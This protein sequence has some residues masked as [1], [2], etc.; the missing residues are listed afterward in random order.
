[1]VNL[2]Q[3]QRQI[4]SLNNGDVNSRREAIR[5][6]TQYERE[7]WAEVPAQTVRPLI[8]SL[9]RQLSQGKQ[10]VD[11]IALPTFRQEVATILGKIGPGSEVAVP[12]LVTLLEA[13]VADGVRE[14]AATALGRIG[15]EARRAVGDL[16]G[17]LTPECRVS[18]AACVAGALGEI[19]CA[20]QRVRSALMNLWMLPIRCDNSRSQ[21]AIALCKLRLEAPGLIDTLAGTLAG[22]AKVGARQTAAE[23]LSWCGKDT[24]G[25]VP[26][27]LAALYD[28]DEQV[29][30]TAEAGL[31]RLRLSQ[32]KAIQICC[33]QLGDCPLAQ[34][35][36]K[37]SGALAVEPLIEVLKSKKAPLREKAAQTLGSLKEIAAPAAAALTAALNDKDWSVRL[38][39]AKALW[40]V[41][42]QAEVVVPTLV[43]LLKRNGLPSA[44]DTADTAELRRTSL[45]TVIEALTRIG[46]LA[47]PA[48]P[49]LVARTRDE[50][51][52][53][54]ESASRAVR[55]IEAVG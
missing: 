5:A 21:V 40:N 47:K 42:K 48:L 34:A 53:V 54:R 1:M 46:P 30:K 17:V 55:A 4:Q 23:A 22:Q 25:V 41:T 9:Q 51:R 35:A 12:D 2:R 37:K 39:V 32:A 31:S 20:D 49:A 10:G 29:R 50:N 24:I 43:N 6:L 18:L 44:A 15:P 13:G 16:L 3:L 33:Q 8:V 11:P 7:D 38:A 27:L 14:A 19:G 28:E 26:A 36:L 52:L 45:Q